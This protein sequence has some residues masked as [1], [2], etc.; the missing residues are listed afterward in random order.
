[1][2]TMRCDAWI[3]RSFFALDELDTDD[4]LK[5]ARVFLGSE[6]QNLKTIVGGDLEPL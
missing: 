5:S 2:K 3:I 6:S 1:M 4:P